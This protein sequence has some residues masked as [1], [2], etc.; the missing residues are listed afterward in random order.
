MRNL[1]GI[2]EATVTVEVLGLETKLFD[3][4][5]FIWT[6]VSDNVE[7]IVES[8]KIPVLMRGPAS[9]ISRVTP[10]NIR[11]E[12]DLS[13]LMENLGSHFVSVKVS[14]PAVPGVGAIQDQGVPDYTVA[15]RLVEK[16]D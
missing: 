11:V 3:V 5:Q 14:V 8:A 10:Y 12:A 16:E 6:G 1:S 4:D 15:I 9:L 13:S 2:T 7:V